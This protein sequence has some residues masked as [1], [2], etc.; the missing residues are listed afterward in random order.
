MARSPAG[1]VIDLG[2][3]TQFRDEAPYLAEWIRY[4]RL[5]GVSQFWLY[6]D[7]STDD[8]RSAISA[9]LRDGVV[10]VIPASSID[11]ADTRAPASIRQLVTFRDGLRRS[12]GEARWVALIDVD[13]FL[14]PMLD[15]TI[16]ECLR[17]FG[18]RQA[19]A[20]SIATAI[21]VNWRMFGTSGAIVPIG[22]PILG[23]LTACSAVTHPDNL[24]GKSLVRPDRVDVDDAWTIHHLPLLGD[25]HYL[26]GGD[27][28]LCFRINPTNLRPDLV[29]PR[30]H[31]EDLMIRIN[32]YSLRDEGFYER[33]RVRRAGDGTLP[34]KSLERLTEHHRSFGVEQDRKILDF[35]SAFHPE[36]FEEHWNNGIARPVG[37]R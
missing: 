18:Q 20:D 29:V 35:L 37:P 13:E 2:I 28:G 25:D 3:I 16:P 36:A 22:E 14:L 7:D 11:G 15:A 31:R 33:N 19:N 1:P 6:D 23:K 21:Y 24:N 27:R 12:R 17:R 32:H 30:D 26:D 4:H 10:E 34:G 9:D 5:A 8:W